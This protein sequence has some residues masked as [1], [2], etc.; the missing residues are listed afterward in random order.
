MSPCAYSRTASVYASL[1]LATDWPLRSTSRALN[2]ARIAFLASRVCSLRVSL[3]RPT[4]RATRE[5]TDESGVQGIVRYCRANHNWYSLTITPRSLEF[6]SLRGARLNNGNAQDAHHLVET[7]RL[8]VSSTYHRTDSR[9]EQHSRHC[10]GNTSEAIRQPVRYAK[11]ITDRIAAGRSASTERYCSDSKKPV[12]F[13]VTADFL[14]RLPLGNSGRPIVPDP[15]EWGALCGISGAAAFQEETEHLCRLRVF[16]LA[17]RNASLPEDDRQ[18]SNADVA[19][20]WVG[21]CENG[22]PSNHELMATA[23]EW[24]SEA[25]APERGDELPSCDGSPLRHQLARLTCTR[26][27]PR[28]GTER[29]RETRTRTPSS[30]TSAS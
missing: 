4:I 27:V 10:S 2:S 8:S 17:A 15:P 29:R 14:E 3:R 20:M 26:T 7:Y 11:V 30:T 25:Q 19:G 5:A 1:I 18:E 23:G 16:P 28:G 9:V 24:S 12:R 6:Q 22:I 21:Y 13:R